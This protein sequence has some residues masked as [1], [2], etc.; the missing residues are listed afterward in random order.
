MDLPETAE[1]HTPL[2]STSSK[3]RTELSENPFQ[4]VLK[5]RKDPGLQLKKEKDQENRAVLDITPVV[6]RKNSYNNFDNT[7]GSRKPLIQEIA[8][9]E[10]K[11]DI[12][13]KATPFGNVTTR[14]PR[15]HEFLRGSVPVSSS[16]NL[17]DKPDPSPTQVGGELYRSRLKK[18]VSYKETNRKSCPNVDFQPV[19][20][21]STSRRI[22]E[23]GPK[24]T[25]NTED[26]WLEKRRSTPIIPTTSTAVSTKDSSTRSDS[27]SDQQPEKWSV[28]RQPLDSG[29]DNRN[30]QNFTEK[31]TWIK[32]N[33]DQRRTS[34]YSF[35]PPKESDSKEPNEAPWI[36]EFRNS[37]K[38]VGRI[39]SNREP[40][41][42]GSDKPQSSSFEATTPVRIAKPLSSIVGEQSSR[43][44]GGRKLSLNTSPG[45]TVVEKKETPNIL[46]DVSASPKYRV[47][48]KF[49]FQ[50]TSEGGVSSRMK[51]N[52]SPVTQTSINTAEPYLPSWSVADAGEAPASL[53]DTRGDI[54]DWQRKLA[55]KNKLRKQ[56]FRRIEDSSSSKG[57]T[58]DGSP[59]AVQPAWRHQLKNRT[60]SGVGEQGEKKSA[61]KPDW[62]KQAE[63]RRA[64]LAQNKLL[65][66]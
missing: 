64:R 55:E 53:A 29:T 48:R 34:S 57:I 43:E 54:P 6:L 66:E 33:L 27:N 17:T 63:E 19:V 65:G 14:S 52:R 24:T 38:R 36:K 7:A 12:P 25:V 35:T 22:F 4:H 39:F 42:S 9:D 32:K 51:E 2:S 45:S 11:V 21:R 18:S 1:E 31:P 16:E 20:L 8:F 62:I 40:L 28:I 26:D 49:S 3:V 23:D 61:D 56:S 37:R 44:V 15:H 50:S 58:D 46:P 13:E 10:K 60:S 30:T 59:K 41:K 47:E 5:E